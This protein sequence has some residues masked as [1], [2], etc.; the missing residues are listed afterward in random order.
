MYRLETIF[1]LTIEAAVSIMRTRKY[2]W[3]KEGYVTL[4]EII[5]VNFSENAQWKVVIW[6]YE[7][8][9]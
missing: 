7:E 2:F 8:V 3:A 1:A 6:G 5:E 4:A 9:F